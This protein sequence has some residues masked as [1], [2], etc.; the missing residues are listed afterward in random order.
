PQ[1]SVPGHHRCVA[2]A[3]GNIYSRNH[4]ITQWNRMATPKIA[5]HRNRV[6]AF[7]VSNCTIHYKAGLAGCKDG[8][9]QIVSDQRSP[10]DLP[11]KIDHENV[12]WLQQIDHALIVIL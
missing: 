11:E 10:F 5:S 3:Y 9:G 2:D 4:D 8:R 7:Q 12:A 1:H 6:D